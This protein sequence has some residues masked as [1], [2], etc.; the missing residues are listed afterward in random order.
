MASGVVA[1]D[2]W[3]CNAGRVVTGGGSQWGVASDSDPA[4]LALWW[5]VAVACGVVASESHPST[6][7]IQ[8]LVVMASGVT[9]P[10]TPHPPN[11]GLVVTGGGGQ[12]GDGFWFWPLNADCM[13]MGGSGLYTLEIAFSHPSTLTLWWQMGLSVQF[14]YFFGGVLSLPSQH[15][16]MVTD[17]SGW[18]SFCFYREGFPSL[19][20]IGLVATDWS[21]LY[22][23]C[24]C[25]CVYVW[26]GGGHPLTSQ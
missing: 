9:A 20:S 19:L 15:W 16:P 10:T 18:Y 11:T 26:L 6:L 12:S 3:P 24:V 13:V 17:G 22:C 14:F 7:A 8:W 4:T 1:S 2:F 23:V 21:G 25:V 5:L